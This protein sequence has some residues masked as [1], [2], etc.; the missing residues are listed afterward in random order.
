M[1][2]REGFHASVPHSHEARD[3][4]VGSAS[5]YAP[6]L[7]AHVQGDGDVE[8]LGADQSDHLHLDS[9]EAQSCSSESNYTLSY[10]EMAVDYP[11]L[12]SHT[13]PDLESASSGTN[14]LSDMSLS[15]DGTESSEM[16]HS[17]AGGASTRS[18][19]WTEDA[20]ALAEARLGKRNKHPKERAPVLRELCRRKGL[21]TEGTRKELWKRL[22][23]NVRT[24]VSQSG[25]S[26]LLGTLSTVCSRQAIEAMVE[27]QPCRRVSLEGRL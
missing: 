23:E 3:D 27:K 14:G 26:W 11:P 9:L 22:L 25:F 17:S 21:S 15:L 7:G 4:A 18:D 19:N 16:D 8:M 10:S 5:L 1:I 2:S 6:D 20:I 12:V 13:P 24:S